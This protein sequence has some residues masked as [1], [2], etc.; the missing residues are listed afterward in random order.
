LKI[1]S[2]TLNKKNIGF[3]E[4]LIF[5]LIMISGGL[6][7]F[8]REIILLV[9]AVMIIYR[10][11]KNN[12]KIMGN[13][14]NVSFTIF[15]VIAH[16][17]FFYKD[18]SDAEALIIRLSNL[19]LALLVYIYFYS[20][21]GKNI[22]ASLYIVLKFILYQA[23]ISMPFIYF[24]PQYFTKIY[25]WN[26]DY[27]TF[28]YLF[29]F[30]DYYLTTLPRIAGLF[31]EPGVLQ[32]YMNLL[33][34]FSVHYFNDIKW[35]FLALIVILATQSTI[36]IG[37]LLI[38]II[39]L[40]FAFLKKRKKTNKYIIIALILILSFFTENIFFSNYQEKTEGKSKGSFLARQYDLMIG[41]STIRENPI[42]GIGINPENFVE[43]QK[44]NNINDAFSSNIN[45]IRYTTNSY[46]QLFYMFGIPLSLMFLYFFLN[47]KI[48]TK[49]RILFNIIIILSLSTEAIIFTPFFLMFFVSGL[50]KNSINSHN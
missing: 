6:F 17:L 27:Q 12:T 5:L 45:D 38:Q 15:I 34:F 20:N 50:S 11:L 7:I 47:N 13:Y 24:L 14:L 26:S 46:I 48:V 41:L 23:L 21:R 40:L 42:L 3:D 28:Y 49:N 10:L 33:F 43:Y 31:F 25:L 16:F 18:I 44:K 32:I 8:P 9:L 2:K 22:I 39:F 1:V 19:F 35:S 4:F 29:Y 37:I 30:Q 36:G